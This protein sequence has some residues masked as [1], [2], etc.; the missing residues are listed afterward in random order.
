MAGATSSHRPKNRLNR[1]D[2]IDL[3]CGAPLQD[4]DLYTDP[5]A[6]GNSFGPLFL[7]R[8]GAIRQPCVSIRDLMGL[9]L[10]YRDT[11]FSQSTPL[12]SSNISN[13][14]EGVAHALRRRQGES[15]GR[16]SDAARAI[17]TLI[18]GSPVI[19][20]ALAFP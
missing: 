17:A 10:G 15:A 9:L 11:S 2:L 5:P 18:A 20:V 3:R 16:F 8:T 13:C 7:L 6:N 12:I 14:R 4:P 19:G 1:H